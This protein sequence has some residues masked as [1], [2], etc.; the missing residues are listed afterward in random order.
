MK[1]YATIVAFLFLSVTLH[2]KCVLNGIYL[3]STNRE[4]FNHSYIIIE[5]LEGSKQIAEKLNIHYPVF[6]R[7]GNDKIPLQ[8]EE[9]LTGGYRKTQVIVRLTKAPFPGKK[10]TLIIGNLKKADAKPEE[11]NYETR[12]TEPFIFTGVAAPSVKAPVFINAPQE[13][14]KTMVSYGCGP[15]RWIYYQFSSSLEN[16][17]VKAALTDKTTGR[18]TTYIVAAE[19]DGTLKIGH[20]MCSGSFG[21][22]E[23]H[24]YE[25]S[26]SLL[27]PGGNKSTP[28]SA[29]TVVPP[30]KETE[31]E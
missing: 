16:I 24:Q 28:A 2:A 7:A 6:L 30:F 12:K 23:G 29:L 15:A 26:F 3:T 31:E 5:F 20:G 13:L 25:I 21:F 11:Y 8:V 17:F 4:V 9:I 14:K 10:Y 1:L 27:D 19:K 22:S 18:T